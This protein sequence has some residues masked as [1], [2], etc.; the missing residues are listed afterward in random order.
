MSGCRH[1]QL[2]TSVVSRYGCHSNCSTVPCW[3]CSLFQR[4]PCF[5]WQAAH[6]V[7]SPGD[8]F[9]GQDDSSSY[10]TSSIH[11]GFVT[12][13]MSRRDQLADVP[14][15]SQRDLTGAQDGL[16]RLQPSQEI[17]LPLSAPG[18]SVFL[19]SSDTSG[20]QT[21]IRHESTWVF[22]ILN[23]LSSFYKHW[24]RKKSILEPSHILDFLRLYLNLELIIVS[25]PDFF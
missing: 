20:V 6:W 2:G 1:W 17:P 22:C 24:D 19:P 16:G 7:Y 23:R 9:P 21:L 3:T 14:S 15:T 4:L 8:V 11:A 18:P 12:R 25:P 5:G 10:G 13:P